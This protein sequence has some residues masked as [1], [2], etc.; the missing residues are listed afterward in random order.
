MK[1]DAESVG[2]C[3]V[4]LTVRADAEET[5]G[6]YRKVVGEFVKKGR[7][8]GF[9]PGHAPREVILQAF[10]KEITEQVSDALVRKFYEP[11]LKERQIRIS[12][13]IAVEDVLFTPETG[14]AFSLTLD[15]KPEFDL[16]KY[17]GIPL[18][19]E[20]PSVDAAQ[21][22]AKIETMRAAL[23]KFTDAGP[24]TPAGDGDMVAIDFS[25]TVDGAPI[26]EI[27][28]DAA[29]LSSGQDFWVRIGDG[30]RFIPEVVDALKGMRAGES[31]TVEFPFPPDAPHESLRGR[32]AAFALTVKKVRACVPP[33]DA[34]FLKRLSLDSMD[35]LREKVRKGLQTDADYAEKTRR[36]REIRTALLMRAGEFDLPEN[37]VSTA[38]RNLLAEMM[39]QAERQGIPPEEIKKHRSDIL[40]G[41]TRQAR[42]I[43]RLRYLFRAVAGAEKIE[44]SEADVDARFERIAALSGKGATPSQLRADFERRGIMDGIRDSVLESKC[45]DFL[46]AEAKI[47]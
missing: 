26:A 24:D 20:T 39:G 5:R 43:L 15:V 27:A 12:A 42:Q 11:A 22:D 37:E 19:I 18:R 9:R 14:I 46:I 1:V 40:E 7:V 47:Q 36:E 2:P 44:V 34:A 17:K 33:D 10:H 35:D 29:G 32:Q 41:V 25:G 16:P 21:V 6:D 13:L 4:R 30:R 31:K 23:A 8:R 28:P 3:R 45:L 38:V